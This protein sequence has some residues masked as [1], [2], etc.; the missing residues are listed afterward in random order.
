MMFNLGTECDPDALYK[1]QKQVRLSDNELIV[2]QSQPS[3]QHL[4]AI[5]IHD[6][7]ITTQSVGTGDYRNSSITISI[8]IEVEPNLTKDSH[9]TVNASFDHPNAPCPICTRDALDRDALRQMIYRLSGLG[10]QLGSFLGT[11]LAAS[12]TVFSATLPDPV[13]PD[14]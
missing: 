4:G 12:L 6:E 7:S 3:E 2:E 10:L 13:V 5:V 8:P 11:F 1:L 9:Q 14:L